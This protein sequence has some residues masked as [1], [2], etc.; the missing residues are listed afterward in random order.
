M[1]HILGL[2][3]IS[4]YIWLD[5]IALDLYYRLSWLL[6][7]I[8]SRPRP[9]LKES[10]SSL[11][12]AKLLKILQ[13]NVESQSRKSR[14]PGYYTE[15]NLYLKYVSPRTL[16]YKWMALHHWIYIFS[17]SELICVTVQPRLLSSTV[18]TWETWPQP[19]LMRSWRTIL[20][21]CL[22]VPHPSRNWSLWRDASDRVPS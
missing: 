4:F 9:L 15:F 20:K 11:K 14:I 21:L 2:L 16:I 6:V 3:H 5:L 10:E 7:I 1:I 18:V 12:E 8:P 13:L 22:P 19:R 17:K